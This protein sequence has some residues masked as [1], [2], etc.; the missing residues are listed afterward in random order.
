[1]SILIPSSAIIGS[2]IQPQVYLVKGGKAVLQKVS[3]SRRIGNKA[4]IENGVKEGD[5]IITSGFINLY[6]GAN[7]V[8][9]KN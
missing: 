3:I 1:K 2:T 9:S 7:V 5:V 4:V 8:N 6:D